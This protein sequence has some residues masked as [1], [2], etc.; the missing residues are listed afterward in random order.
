MGAIRYTPAYLIPLSVVIGT[1][2][3]GWWVWYT[4]ILVFVLIPVIEL[5]AGRNTLNLDAEAESRARQQSLYS[6]ILWSFVPIQLGLTLFVLWTITRGHLSTHEAIGLVVSLGISNGGVGITIAHELVHRS[7]KLEQILGRIL[8]MTTWYMHFAIEHVRGHHV[9][10]ATA[11]DPATARLN[12]S[13][14]RF[15]L[16]TVPRQWLS[17]WQLEIKRL[18]KLGRPVLS[19]RNEMLWFLVVQIA[20]TVAIGWWLGLFAVAGFLLSCLVA[21]SL[22]E[23]VNY[24]EHYGLE[25]RIDEHGRPERVN[26]EHSWNSDHVVSRLFLFELSRHSD[27]HATASR[28][29]QILRSFEQSPQLPTGYPGMVVLALMPPIWFAIMNPLAEKYCQTTKRAAEM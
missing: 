20:F 21:F 24:L 6:W 9:N 12:T 17:A 28:K 2:A 25:R 27:H 18:H 23:A 29:Y 15:W 11:S 10:V 3:Q 22:L 14:Y 5:L 7:S 13:F 16:R 4:P 19:V 1:L 8:L 26:P